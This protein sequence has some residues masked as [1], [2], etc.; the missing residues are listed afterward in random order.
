MFVYL[1]AYYADS[2]YNIGITDSYFIITGNK[3]EIIPLFVIF[4]FYKSLSP[5]NNTET[6][7]FIAQSF[8]NRVQFVFRICLRSLFTP[9]CKDLIG[10]VMVMVMFMLVFVIVVVVV[11][12]MLVF[13]FILVIVVMMMAM[14]VFVFI[15][16]VMMMA[17]LVFVF[18]IVV[19]MMVMFMLFFIE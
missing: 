9:T 4:C 5:Q 12:A 16:V 19:M 6:G 10:M 11:M 15:I 1:G 13:V 7:I 17:M 2:T 18:V 8:K 3:I 14:L